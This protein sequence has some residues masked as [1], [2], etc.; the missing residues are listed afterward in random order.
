[1]SS[2]SP[3]D[4]SPFSRIEPLSDHHTCSNARPS[5]EVYFRHVN[6]KNLRRS[7]NPKRCG[8]RTRWN[9][10]P[11]LYE[12]Y[13]PYIHLSTSNNVWARGTCC[14]LP[15]NIDEADRTLVR[16][17]ENQ[18]P[19]D[20]TDDIPS[21]LEPTVQLGTFTRQVAYYDCRPRDKSKADEGIADIA[22]FIVW[23]GEPPR[24][25]K[26]KAHECVVT[27]G[28]LEIMRQR[29]CG[30]YIQVDYTTEHPSEEKK[31][32]ES[33]MRALN[34]LSKAGAGFPIGK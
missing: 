3:S 4:I 13:A 17:K 12:R 19:T 23:Q 34:E 20:I 27:P 29:N 22:A 6:C 2:P 11:T 32:R 7:D 21:Y 16:V 9:P 31:Q 1:M 26:G 5:Y 33:M 8:F 28:H 30:D 24:D 15:E 25:L 14:L 18:L 10:V